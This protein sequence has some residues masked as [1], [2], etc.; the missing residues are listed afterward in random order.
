MKDFDGVGR[1]CV[2]YPVRVAANDG[3]SNMLVLRCWRNVWMF[4]EQVQRFMNCAEHMLGA[5]RTSFNKYCRIDSRSA[6][7]K[8]VRLI[9]I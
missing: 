1:D 7:A 3:G 9:F 4:A 5:D 8:G 2:K 6:S